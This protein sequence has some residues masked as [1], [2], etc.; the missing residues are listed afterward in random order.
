[1]I[2]RRPGSVVRAEKFSIPE[3][4][5][6]QISKS[7]EETGFIK[8][9]VSLAVK[10]EDDLDK[11]EHREQPIA[12]ESAGG[13]S[14]P[15]LP[16]KEKVLPLEGEPIKE[17]QIVKEKPS[18][19]E[20]FDAERFKAFVESER[21]KKK[22]NGM[23]IPGG[24]GFIFLKAAQWD[25]SRH[26]LPGELIK[27]YIRAPVSRHFDAVSDMFLF[28]KFLR[29][30]SI[31]HFAAYRGHGLWV[32][33]NFCASDGSE[34]KDLLELQELFQWE[35]AM[36]AD[37]SAENLFMEYDKT[38]EQAFL[39]VKGF[40]LLLE[41]KSELAMDASMVSF[42]SGGRIPS[43]SYSSS[44]VQKAMERLSN[45]LVSNIQNAVFQRAPGEDR[46]DRA[47]YDMAAVFENVPGKRIIRA[48]VI[49][50]QDE[51]I[52]G[53]STIPFQ[54]RNFLMGIGP[55]QKEF[56]ELAGQQKQSGKATF[57]HAQT[58]RVFYY[59]EA[60]TAFLGKQIYRDIKEAKAVMVW[61][62][63]ENNPC[64]AVLT[65]NRKGGGKDILNTYLSQW[66]YLGET[67]KEDP[68]LM[69]DSGI[70]DQNLD[71]KKENSTFDIFVDFVE[72]LH[73]YCQR[74]FFPKAYCKIDI[75]QLITGIYSVPGACWGSADSLRVS[76]DVDR[77][78]VYRNDLEYAVKRVNERHIRDYL[79]RRLWLEI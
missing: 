73:R 36:K 30:E 45:C 72:S 55:Q 26:S 63:G 58:D 29:A 28:F 34:E 78:S 16:I 5:K 31:D 57:Y 20:I 64:W 51:E 52:A 41:D 67:L 11:R 37:P 39:E 48:S 40:K 23:P 22:T 10:R 25:I 79:D 50:E 74:Y 6:R 62:E 53:F 7:L 1:M 9:D 65:N 38:K 49:D 13:L 15:D 27:K 75:T 54:K 32:F 60:E 18:K 47:F 59:T 56:R 43:F 17:R 61:K 35:K 42:E 2:G 33:N 71:K 70:K 14:I 66:P 3:G 12:E 44:P 76:L 21:R 19:K 8:E 4:K 24:C 68:I 77:N 69:L 46:L